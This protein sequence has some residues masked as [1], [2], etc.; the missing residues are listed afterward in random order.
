MVGELSKKVVAHFS[1]YAGANCPTIAKAGQAYTIFEN[2]QRAGPEAARK[3]KQYALD[4]LESIYERCSTLCPGLTWK[5]FLPLLEKATEINAW[6]FKN[7]DVLYIPYL[8]LC[9]ATIFPPIKNK[10]PSPLFFVL[11]P[12]SCDAEFWHQPESEKQRIWRVDTATL[13]V[14]DIAMVL[15]EVEPWYRRRAKVALRL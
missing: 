1:H 13:N 2:T 3:V 6:S 7:F 12:G 10:R 14:D 11:E 8:L 4:N 9:C 15:K 5:E